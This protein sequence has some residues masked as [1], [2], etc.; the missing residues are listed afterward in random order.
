MTSPARRQQGAA[1][2]TGSRPPAGGGTRPRWL[3]GGAAGVVLL[4][5]VVLPRLLTGS[6]ANLGSEGDRT[7]TSGEE[8]LPAGSEEGWPARD[9]APSTTGVVA[10]DGS[11]IVVIDPA[12]EV[13]AEVDPPSDSDEPRPVRRVAVRPG[14]TLDELTV[15]FQRCGDVEIGWVRVDATGTTG[16]VLDGTDGVFC[17]TDPVWSPDGRSLWWFQGQALFVHRWGPDG[18]GESAD[19]RLRLETRNCYVG[20][21]DGDM[22]CVKGMAATGPIRRSTSWAWAEPGP[23]ASEGVLMPPAG[24]SVLVLPVQR[25]AD[26]TIWP[27]PDLTSYEQMAAAMNAATHRHD[28]PTYELGEMGGPVFG[29][30]LAR[31]SGDGQAVQLPVSEVLS[32]EDEDYGATWLNA[33]DDTAVF[34]AFGHAQAWLVRWEGDGWGRLVAL[35]DVAHADVVAAAPAQPAP[36]HRVPAKPVF[37][38]TD[39]QVLTLHGPQGQVEVAHADDGA[40]RDFTLDPQSMSRQGTVVWRQG[41]GCDA[42]LHFLAY[43]RA[44]EGGVKTG[45]KT[46][47]ATCPGRPVF[48]PSGD[49]VAWVSHHPGGGREA[50]FVLEVL[51]VDWRLGEDAPYKKEALA[52]P[53]R[54]AGIVGL[55]LVDWS[56]R[57][58]PPGAPRMNELHLAGYG[59]GGGVS[60]LTAPVEFISG[61]PDRDR[62]VLPDGAAAEA[63]P[64]IL[65]VDSHLPRSDGAS[66]RYTLERTAGR[67]AGGLTVTRHA[68]GDQ[69]DRLALPAGLSVDEDTWMT[70]RGNDVFLGDGAGRAW[71][72]PW[73][74]DGWARLRELDGDIRYAVPLGLRY[75][76][77]DGVRFLEA[78][79]AVR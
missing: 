62:P 69:A 52:L 13:V 67:D 78:V 23:Q 64:A 45:T 42:T 5:A 19:D 7:L 34:G 71:W 59:G 11:R 61:F 51:V 33:R 63:R 66:A 48:A 37:V 58:D 17:T 10:T 46:L 72:A 24:N 57:P 6:G 53:V 1:S 35:T 47:P 16:G 25:R 73:T 22:P 55:E 9:V 21:D 8:A 28:Q 54:P 20:Q 12:G 40:V 50:A 30:V 56:R 75:G 60:A 26:G 38:S 68:D 4:G 74:R 36:V 79:S 41:S 31:S 65:Q 2:R 43:L 15:V 29:P 49:H 76:E 77:A 44:P 14:S 32:G 3:L 27:R 70:A 18:P 39:G